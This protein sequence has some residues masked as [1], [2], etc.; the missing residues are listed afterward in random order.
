MKLL[1]T[2]ATGF[3]GRHLV[4]RLV[5]EGLQ[6]ISLV[7]RPF[8]LDDWFK[9]NIKYIIGDIRFK[10]SLDKITDDIDIVIHTAAIFSGDWDNYYK[11]NVEATRHLLEYSI[12]NNVKRF[13]YISSVSVY[14]H[15]HLTKN[16]IFSEDWPIEDIPDTSFY[17]RSKIEAE[18]LVVELCKKNDLPFV[19]LRPGAIYGPIGQLFPATMGLP[20]GSDKILM[21]GN[22]NSKLPLIYVENVCDII[23]KSIIN[24][25]ALWNVFNL[26]DDQTISRNE[27]YSLL[28]SK[29]NSRIKKIKFPYFLLALL[30][31]L[32][33]IL[34]KY[35]G[36]KAPL[37]DLN[38]RMFCTTIYY[39][40]EKMK[41]VF[42]N[43]PYVT[44][45]ESLNK[46][47]HY[48]QRKMSPN[49]SKGI[50]KGRIA[51]Q[52]DRVMRVGIIG[53]GYIAG[54]HLKKIKKIKNAKVVAVTDT[55]KTKAEKLAKKFR[56][57]GIFSNYNEMLQEIKLDAV[58]ILAPPQ[59]H[60]EIAK[61][62]LEY[63]CHVLVEKPMALNSNEAKIMNEIALKKNLKLCVAHNFL[64]NDPI[65]KAREIIASGKL[66][67]I[68]NVES[69]YGTLFGTSSPPFDID[70]H[71]MYELPGSLFHD[72]LSHPI[73][74]LLDIM[75][76]ANIKD[77]Y[78]KSVAGVPGIRIDELKV[79]FENDN[80]M[81][82]LTF[83]M[84]TSPRYHYINILGTNGSIKIDFLNNKVILHKNVSILPET[85]SRTF[86]G[87]R[88]SFQLGVAYCKISTEMILGKFSYFNGM[89]RL[90]KLFYR[91]IIFDE[92]VPVSG[93]EAL[94][95]IQ[96]LDQIIDSLDVANKN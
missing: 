25:D 22:S 70:K 17:S 9:E 53:C 88:E 69:W 76:N 83:S 74:L 78:K 84:C 40:N 59:W 7:R 6:V 37:S 19:V 45:E 50:Y 13:I 44:F 63:G 15:V 96:M 68:I 42:G 41:K 93:D 30:K 14:K 2:G 16:Q 33:K 5:H 55:T 28:K 48:F 43:D 3:L 62:A 94:K 26:T 57:E 80:K 46:T 86:W 38:L 51:I 64:F 87:I 90:I 18:K 21:F 36:S 52:S 54:I 10:N 72:F 89:E 79:V 60:F 12:K 1:V 58:H 67:E 95:V 65:I 56:V 71:W 73:Y 32:L 8:R 61:T 29:V 49:R 23:H 47:L 85:M 11:T 4:E 39:S 20:V 34:F 92:P 81:G 27:Y 24:T 77:I 82:I 91:S 35:L 31:F 66:G 75:G